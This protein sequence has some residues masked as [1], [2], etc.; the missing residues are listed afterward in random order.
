MGN[1]LS[2]H[3]SL[4]VH[5]CIDV[6][7]VATTQAGFGWTNGVVLWVA[8]VYGGV[9]VEPHCP[10]LLDTPVV[11]GGSSTSDSPGPTGSGGPTGN[12]A[13]VGSWRGLPSTA[14]LVLA[15]FLVHLL[16]YP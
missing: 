5:R 13:A 3:V 2:R 12:N 9:L 1:T 7:G 14:V 10:N 6:N 4:P 16:S 11:G 15:A 8:S